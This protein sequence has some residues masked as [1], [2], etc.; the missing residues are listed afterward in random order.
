MDTVFINKYFLNKFW[1]IVFCTILT[2]LTGCSPNKQ[3]VK[4]IKQDSDG[5]YASALS[6]DGSLSLMSTNDQQ[7]TLWQLEPIP[8][9]RF[10]WQQKSR[11]NVFIVKFSPQHQFAISASRH[12]FAVWSTKNG[13]SL[14]Y[15]SISESVI[16]DIAISANGQIVLAGLEDGKV[17]AVNLKT[18]RRL[19]FLGHTEAINEV[20]LSA[21]GLY[22]FTAGNGGNALLWNTQTAQIVS[23][24][25]LPGRITQI[26]FDKE[27]HYAFIAD[28]HNH[29]FIYRIPANQKISH[30]SIHTRQQ[31]FTCARFVNHAKWLLTGSPSRKLQ[32]WDR[33][34]GQLLQQWQ[35]GLNTKRRP[36]SAIVFDATLSRHDQIVSSSSSGLIEYW[37]IHQ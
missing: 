17:I 35:V 9:L 3:A 10:R 27:G 24:F 34:T 1:L 11:N 16:R 12:D 22:A 29:A 37:N 26:A 8:K 5:V 21:N 6:D 31:I 36:A 14:G 4:T 28:S 18:G 7:L 15:W 25:K 19:E 32:L 13:H 2:A 23:R 30:L 33:Q 20:R